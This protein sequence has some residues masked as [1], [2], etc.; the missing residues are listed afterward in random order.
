MEGASP[1]TLRMRSRE[2]MT[3]RKSRKGLLCGMAVFA[4]AA[5]FH[6]SSLRHSF[7]GDDFD[8]VVNN[9]F[10]SAWDNVSILLSPRYLLEPYPI[11][12]G[13][14][15]LTLLSLMVDYKLWGTHPLGYHLTHV[16]LHSVNSVL[17]FLLV[18]LLTAPRTARLRASSVSPGR[19]GGWAAALLGGLL[20]A[21]HPVQG[22]AVHIIAYRADLLAA[23]FYL[24]ALV[25]FV[26]GAGKAGLSPGWVALSGVSFVLGLFSK[27]AVVS[28]PAA[29]A[30]YGWLFAGKALRK[31]GRGIAAAAAPPT[32]GLRASNV[33]IGSAAAF[34]VVA[35]AFLFFFWHERM[36]YS[37]NRTIFV[38]VLGNISPLSSIYAYVNTIVLSF[39]HYLKVLAWPVGLSVDYQ[40]AVLSGALDPRALLSLIFSCLAAWIFF[41][42]KNP[43]FRFGLGFWVISYLPASNAVPL[44]NTVA[45]RYMYLPMAGVGLILASA[46]LGLP[47]WKFSLGKTGWAGGVALAPTLM[48]GLI[49]FYGALTIAGSG[50][51]RDMYSLYG[52]A[53]EAAP[54]NARARYNLALAHMEKGDYRSAAGEFER[55]MAL[56]PLFNRIQIWHFLGVC[57]E[58]MGNFEK[59]KSFYRKALVVNPGKETLNNLANIL[60]K[61]GNGDGAAF[62]LKKSLELSPDP[63][64]YNNLG[65]YHAGRKEF[66][67]AIGYFKKTV[68]LEPQYVDAWMNLL[69]A[70]E[71]SGNKKMAAKET[72]RMAGLFQ[73][74][75]WPLEGTLIYAP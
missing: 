31:S 27:E 5:A 64:V 67:Q 16:L 41:S 70:Y 46:A 24:L 47:A 44:V 50:R 62:L 35:G 11:K 61:E 33:P 57:Q 60:W 22:E 40:I 73:A 29:M 71:E 28:L 21:L 65:A 4:A 63:A 6:I 10:I 53:V 54:E 48:A 75:G 56:S 25:G 45:D 12:S 20:F 66:G 15:P 55:A 72:H 58:K 38:N 9:D 36:V 3:I 30:L 68:E 14:R 23:F 18:M 69:N 37:L 49:F 13:A 7:V 42:V 39:L 19:T 52:A 26:Q 8:L 74:N 17:V 51:F 43:L 2:E 32:A 34:A 1:Y 59:A